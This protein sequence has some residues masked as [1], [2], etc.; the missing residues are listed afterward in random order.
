MQWDDPGWM[1]GAHLSHSITALLGCSEERKTL[2]EGWWVEIWAG[3]D[4]LP[5]TV[6]GKTDLTWGKLL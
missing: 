5:I 3:R 1:P 4:H 2:T 6:M